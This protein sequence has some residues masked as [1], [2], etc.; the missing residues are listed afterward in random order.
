MLSTSRQL[1][2]QLLQ[3]LLSK[4]LEGLFP[5]KFLILF[6]GQNVS[7]SLK[8][9]PERALK[10]RGWGKCTENVLGP[11]QARLRNPCQCTSMAAAVI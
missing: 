3:A 2:Q 11:L 9:S 4:A 8:S 6:E 1:L 7:M 10:K 5:P